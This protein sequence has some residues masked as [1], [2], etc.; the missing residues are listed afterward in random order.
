M[1]KI[2]PYDLPK[3][4]MIEIVLTSI[5][6]DVDID[7]EGYNYIPHNLPR[8]LVV[9]VIYDENNSRNRNELVAT[10]IDKATDLTGYC[11]SD[12]DVAPIDLEKE[13]TRTTIFVPEEASDSLSDTLEYEGEI[14]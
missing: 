13:T 2:N 11:I 14:Y 10:A 12:C 6:W 7:T 4:K 3:P 5:A 8:K 9:P 1:T